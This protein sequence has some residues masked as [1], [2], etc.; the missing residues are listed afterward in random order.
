MVGKFNNIF[1]IEP[2]IESA[3]FVVK[4]E[5]TELI[6]VVIWG[7]VKKFGKRFFNGVTKSICNVACSILKD[8]S[9]KRGVKNQRGIK[10]SRTN[11]NIIIDA[12]RFWDFVFL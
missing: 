4:V 1:D 2:V 7:D 10:I 8:W 6:W 3:T 5:S 11:I 9:I 12:E